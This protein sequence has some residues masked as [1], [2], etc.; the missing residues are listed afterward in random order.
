MHHEFETLK[1]LRE[2][3]DG[4]FPLSLTD[5]VI[6]LANAAVG[7]TMGG[8]GGGSRQA[9]LLKGKGMEELKGALDAARKEAEAFEKKVNAAVKKNRKV[10]AAAV[11]H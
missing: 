5:E 1:Q 10:V 2:E 4:G 7:R 3:E 11:G 8:G 6:G 9:D